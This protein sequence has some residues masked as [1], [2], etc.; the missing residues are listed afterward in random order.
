MKTLYIKQPLH[1]WT[2]LV[3]IGDIIM[4]KMNISL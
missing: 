4:V 2:N 1:M 3:L